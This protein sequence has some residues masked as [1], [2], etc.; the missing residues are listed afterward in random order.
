M[1]ISATYH[2]PRLPLD[3]QP[4]GCPIS[5]PNRPSRSRWPQPDR[6]G[7]AARSSAK[8][9]N[10]L[11]VQT[12]LTLPF[13]LFASPACLLAVASRLRCLMAGSEPSLRAAALAGHSRG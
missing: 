11:R 6:G 1:S 10:G 2:T 3:L 13:I 9:Q 8:A 4:A 5:P 12:A 7:V